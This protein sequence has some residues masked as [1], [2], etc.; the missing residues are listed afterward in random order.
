V[1][2][3]LR[4]NGWQEFSSACYLKGAYRMASQAKA[5]ICLIPKDKEA[6]LEALFGEEIAFCIFR[7]SDSLEHGPAPSCARQDERA[8]TQPRSG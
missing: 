8:T 2:R 6:Y 5:A 1:G 3:N 7:R 4:A